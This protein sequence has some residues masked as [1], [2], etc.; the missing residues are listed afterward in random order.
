MRKVIAAMKVSLDGRS[1]TQ[2]HADR[3]LTRVN[4]PPCL[5]LWQGRQR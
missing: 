5:R 3:T 4:N 2:G 1:A